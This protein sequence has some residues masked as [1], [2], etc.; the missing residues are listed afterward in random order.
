MY[1]YNQMHTE[2]SFGYEKRVL[3]KAIVNIVIKN[4]KLHHQIGLLLAATYPF[5][6]IVHGRTVTAVRP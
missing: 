1:E 2:T 4:E 6:V 5:H 3:L